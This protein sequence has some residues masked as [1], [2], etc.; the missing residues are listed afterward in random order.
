MESF[1]YHVYVCDQ[2][3]PEG[4]PCCSAHGSAKVIDALRR[5]IVKQGLGDDVQ[6]TT[7]GSI[8]L[9]ERGPN[10]VVYPEGT[11]YSGVT[12]KD[13]PEIVREH[14]GNGR[15][16]ERLLSGDQAALRAEI[17][18][19][20]KKMMA[21][22]KAKDD[23]GVLPDE[24]QQAISGFRESRAILTAVE[25]DIF[26]VVGDG[27]DSKTVAEKLGTDPKA[28]ESLLNSLAAIDLIEKREAIFSNGPVAAR[29]L[30]AGSPDDSRAAIMHTV[31]LWPRWSTLTECVRQGTSVTY[32]EMPE[33]GEAWTGAFIAA[34]HKSAS[35]RAPMV[36]RAI[37]IEGVR[38]MLDVGGG[39]GAYSIAFARANE[40]LQ[41]DILDLATVVPLTQKHIDEAGLGDRVRTR[42]GDLRVDDLGSG[43]DMVFISAICHMLSP[44]ENK[45]LLKRSFEALGAGGRV[46]VQ[47]FVLNADK[48]KPKTAALFALNMLV[49]TRSGSAYSETEYSEWM[50][51]A[52][53]GDIRPI[54]LPGPTGL[55]VAVRPQ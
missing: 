13:V 28:T 11:W 35:F 1:R 38:R 51:D 43:Y 5:E 12:G 42:V 52:G 22:F 54:V 27:A 8:G 50:R 53:F 55:M 40:G 10:M 29:F 25:L 15:I 46:V 24:L 30:A 39:S 14:F 9:C 17:D 32:K 48:T 34:M 26:S 18:S 20:K 7:S 37:G 16:V 2:K 36:L 33:R 19:N 6:I 4:V 44:S 21:A 45:D 31:H 47:D 41:A 23:A 3:K 49:G